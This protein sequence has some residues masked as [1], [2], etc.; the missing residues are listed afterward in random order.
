[1]AHDHTDAPAGPRARWPEL[2]H[3]SWEQTRHALHMWTQIIGKVRMELGPWIN[4]SWGVV[5]YVTARGLTTGPVHHGT[6]VLQIDVDLLEHR[7]SVAAGDG[8]RE[9]LPLRPRSVASFHEELFETLA[10]LEVDVAIDPDPQEIEDP[11]PFPDDHEHRSYDPAHAE[12]LWRAFVQADRVLREF[13]A[14]FIGKCS[15][16]HYFWG[17]MDLAVTRFSG[18]E[19]PEHPGGIPNMP[20]EI[21]REAY[22][23]ECCSAGF[24]PGNA[25]AP[26]PFFYSHAWP[27][28]DGFREADVRPGAAG[29]SEELG[30]WVLPYAAVRT[31][32]DPDAVLLDFLQGAWEAAADLGGW[33]R[34][35]LERPA[36]WRPL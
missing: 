35:A 36:G 1:M 13:R 9:E 2:P 6:G 5:L 21:A 18:R 3:E 27:E 4:H 29:Y 17:A 26:E 7:L 14:R 12:A 33:D 11:V 28:P 24:W 23:H 8:W 22:S 16:V 30:E 31:A 15:P 25:D 32:D 10:R 34:E 19:A 20:D